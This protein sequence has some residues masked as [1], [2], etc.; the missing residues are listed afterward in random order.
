MK[1]VFL[2]YNQ[3]M[4]GRVMEILEDLVIRGYTLWTE[5]KGCGS[6]TGEPHLGTHTWPALNHALMTVL[7]E[8]KARQLLERLELLNQKYPDPGLRAFVWDVVQS[9]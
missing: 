5:V 2:A 1:A 4:S 3:S 8:E 9:I 7:D 6:V